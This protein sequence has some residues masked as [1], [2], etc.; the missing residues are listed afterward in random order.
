[1]FEEEKNNFSNEF[2][3]RNFALPFS[4][5][6]K[7]IITINSFQLIVV[8]VV[9]VVVVAAPN[10]IPFCPVESTAKLNQREDRRR[11]FIRFYDNE[12]SHKKLNIY[13]PSTRDDVAGVEEN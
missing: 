3:V 1:L 10:K 6:Y 4:L 7:T 13:F 11:P 5:K 12:L 8:V 2:C 9:V